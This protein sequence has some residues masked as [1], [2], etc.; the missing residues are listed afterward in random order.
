MRL[1]EGVDY[2]DNITI[3][4]KTAGKPHRSDVSFWR[5]EHTVFHPTDDDLA[6]L[7][8]LDHLSIGMPARPFVTKQSNIVAFGSCFAD[9]ISYYLHDRGFNVSTKKD[10]VAHISRMGDGIVN[11]YA[12]LQ[13][14]EWA[15]NGKVPT[16][17]LWH[18]WKA[19]T[20]GYD[21]AIRSATKAILDKADVFI[22]T[23]GLSEIW[24][25][26]PTGEVFWRAVPISK[27]DPKRHKFRVATQRE[28]FDNIV[29]IRN[30][31]R[32]HRPNAQV[33]FTLSPVPL[34]AT[35]RNMSAMVANEASKA[36]LRSALDELVSNSITTAHYFPAYE[37]ARGCF[38]HQFMEDRRHIH[39]HIIEFVMAMFERYYCGTISAQVLRTV[40]ERART[41]DW[42]VGR[43]G[44]WSVPRKSLKYSKAPGA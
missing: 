10:A 9:N 18:G 33:I 24:Y 3:E 39:F 28:N 1:A 8:V 16:Q 19:E 27:F 22:I 23:L 21:G 29:S 41:H 13:Q 2:D 14:F 11:T 25:D 37:L 12:V 40:Y 44:H 7:S 34:T 5:G 32:W 17:E 4:F 36:N 26:E 42:Y 38:N 30:L 6:S 20:A 35:F 31:I 43:N 15:W